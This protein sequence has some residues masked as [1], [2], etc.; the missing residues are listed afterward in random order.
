MWPNC[1]SSVP[2]TSPT[3]IIRITKVGK[4]VTP[5]K[6]SEI[7]LP[8]F[9]SFLTW[10]SLSRYISFL[11]LSLKIFMACRILIP[12][13]INKEKYSVIWARFEA[14]TIA[15]T[16]GSLIIIQSMTFLNCRLPLRAV[17]RPTRARRIPMNK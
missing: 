9:R 11:T 16:T 7:L 8:F 1:S 14:V 6:A 5:P 13:F 15:P 2:L 12:A 4:I 3:L 10:P 17:N